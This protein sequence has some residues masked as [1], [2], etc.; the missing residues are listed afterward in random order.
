MIWSCW[1]PRGTEM[2]D[3]M[4]DSR[5]FM[6]PLALRAG[7]ATNEGLNP[8]KKAW[9]QAGEAELMPP[10]TGRQFE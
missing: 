4:P 1:K 3:A 2:S 8:K 5:L 7:L 6:S 9:T 10:F